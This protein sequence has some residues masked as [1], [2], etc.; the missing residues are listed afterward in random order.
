MIIIFNK[1]S[2]ELYTE[3]KLKNLIEKTFGAWPIIDDQNWNEDEFDP[4]QFLVA[5]RAFGKRHILKVEIDNNIYESN[6]SII[7]VN[8]IRGIKMN[9][10]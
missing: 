7:T 4:I 9:F 1:G 2:I 6:K 3:E 10:L 8:F 5:Y